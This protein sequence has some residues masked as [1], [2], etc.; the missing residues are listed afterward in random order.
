MKAEIGCWYAICCLEDLYQI[1]SQ[2]E[3][4]EVNE[5]LTDEDFAVRIYETREAA[6]REL[7]PEA[8]KGGSPSE[9]VQDRLGLTAYEIVGYMQ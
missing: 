8:V 1:E 6:L 7:I 9:I 5:L 3:L 2:G 4:E